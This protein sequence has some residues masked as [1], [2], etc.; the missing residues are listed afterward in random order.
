MGRGK[1]CS[2]E[3]REIIK[4][5]IFEGK[6]YAEIRSLLGCSNKMIRNAITFVEKCESRGRKP[7]MSTLLVHRLVRQSRKEPF[8]TATELKKELKISACVETVRARLREHNLNAC[9][10]R[11]VP[12]LSAKHVA[13][14][15]Q[16]AKEHLNWPI[17]KWRNILW[18]DESKIVLFGGKG[19]RCYVRR[20]PKAEYN[21]SFTCKTVKHGGSSIMIW[22]CFS[23]YGVGPIHWIKT[24]MDQHVY[25]EVLE[26]VMLPYAEEEL[27]LLWVFQQDND[28]KHTSKKA[29]KW[30][31]DNGINVMGWP[32]QSPDLNPIENLWADVK[33]DVSN[34]KPRNNEELWASVQES[35]SKISKKRCEDLINSMPRRCAAVIKNKGHATK[36]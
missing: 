23:Y 21:P 7:V 28:P 29:R 12:L 20:P 31:E 18:T 19:S 10:P 35:W 26:N 2:A 6:T 15:I 34:V 32:A 5:M 24:I 13:K 30:F 4:K 1:H 9:S 14:R 8:K 16:F 25:V 33:K 36:Y 11:K 22:A 27:P 17:E 3:K